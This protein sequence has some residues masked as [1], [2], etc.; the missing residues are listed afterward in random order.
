MAR[1]FAL[2]FAAFA[3][4]S[5]AYVAYPQ[6]A[7]AQS[8]AFSSVS[9]EGNERVSADTILSYAGIKRGE[10]ISAAQLNDGYQA[11]VASG[12]F[13]SVEMIPQG[14]RLVIKVS[15]FPFVSRV[16]FEGNRVLKDDQLAALVRT[17]PRRVFSPSVAEQD[18]AAIA[19]A[20][21]AKGQLVATV[22]PQIIRRSGNRVDVVYQVTEG[23]GVE[24][25]RVSF[26]GNRSF[27]DARLRR[28]LET[29]QAGLLRFIVGADTYNPDRIDFDRQV[30]TDFYNS[31]G[32]IDFSVLNVSAEFSRERNAH[33]VTFSV[34]EGQSYDFGNVRVTSEIS[35]ADQAEFG[36]LVN[37]RKGQTYNPVAIENVISRMEAL[38]T[39]KGIDF[40]RVEPRITR[41][42]RDLEL[43]LEFVLVRGPRVFVE[44]IDIEGNKTTLDRVVRNQ[45]RVVE[46]DPFNPR[47]IR[48][49]A[50]RIRALGYFSNAN[51]DARE[52]SSSDRVVIDVDVEEAPTGSFSFGANYSVSE[53]AN[54]LASFSERNFLGRGQTLAFDLTTQLDDGTL[55]FNFIEPAFLGRDVAFGFGMGIA[56]SQPSYALHSERAAY[57]EPSLTFPLSQRTRLRLDAR[58]EWSEI[59]D[60][61]GAPS[62]ISSD[63]AAGWQRTQTLGYSLSFDSR[64]NNIDADYHYALRFGQDYTVGGDV[65][66]VRTSAE[67]TASK[68]I[69]NDDVTLL[70]TIEGGLISS[71][72]GTRVTDRFFN[73]SDIIRGFEPGGIGPREGTT[74]LGGNKYAVA[75]VEAQFP[76]GLPEEYG[77]KGGLFLDHGAVWGL[78]NA[79]G[80]DDDLYWRT[81][82]GASIFWTTPIGPL[83]FNFSKALNKETYDIEQTFDLTIST[84]F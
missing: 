61:G 65:D 4:I 81:V 68:K 35:E 7:Y 29:K 67:I 76:L 60:E 54:L 82:A 1:V 13:E 57:I 22:T 48:E 75:R 30:L 23:K 71:D 18:A 62:F 8:Y 40:L 11:V 33:F 46:G 79:V 83:R 32:Y 9:V 31:R 69:F 74:A 15:E 20:Y 56:T 44:R 84:E 73:S 45:F 80:I 42:N 14:S 63:I 17:A 28:V 34:Q 59:R 72:S 49:A 38:A 47:E 36:K 16:N 70:A 6:A 5:T 51:V 21:A 53:G 58:A 39:R 24:I 78:D 64:R 37:I 12:L 10:R 26:V 2:S 19:E 25:E 77:I 41:N 3:T 43:D 27:S 55:R 66:F 50:S 52:G